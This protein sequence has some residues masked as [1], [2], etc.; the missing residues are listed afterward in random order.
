MTAWEC[1]KHPVFDTVRDKG[2]ENM[3]QRMND[4]C[5]ILLPVDMDD[6][7]DYDNSKNAKF[8]KPQLI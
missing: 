2:K 8:G 6:A 1:L 7:F 5:H 3:L 4:N